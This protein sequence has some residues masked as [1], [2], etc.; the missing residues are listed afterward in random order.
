[1][2][3]YDFLCKKAIEL[4]TPIINV[5]REYTQH[6]FLD[7]FYQQANSGKILFK[8]GTALRI[9]Y[10]SPR[11]SEDLDFSSSWISQRVIDDILQ[12]TLLAI[13]KE[14]IPTKISEA[15]TTTGGYLAKIIL[16][17][18]DQEVSIKL[19]I[20]LRGRHSKENEVTTIIDPFGIGYNI[21]HLPKNEIVLEK[22]QAFLTRA[23]PRDYY[24]LYFII[25]S[26]LLPPVIQLEK[27]LKIKNI[28]EA[29]NKKIDR[30]DNSMLKKELKPLLPKSHWQIINNF[31]ATLNQELKRQV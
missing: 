21:Y 23:K 17:L 6:L 26:R 3:T 4:Q 28:K 11:F 25:R 2:I 22:I 30:A 12:G 5:L 20:S 1:M 13:E 31:S 10:N 24:D 19:E 9:I 16:T 15:K 27:Q 7:Y 8:G 29:L 14:G 18:F